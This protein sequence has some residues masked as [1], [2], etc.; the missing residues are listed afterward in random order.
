MSY[1]LIFTFRPEIKGESEWAGEKGW[2]GWS[3]LCPLDISFLW[4][5]FTAV[6]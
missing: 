1:V 4:S 6:L 5:L 2:R 3:I